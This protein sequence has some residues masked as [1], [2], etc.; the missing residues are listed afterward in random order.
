MNYLNADDFLDGIAGEA[1]DMEIPGL[2]TVKIRSLEYMDLQRINKMARG[3]EM[4]AGFQI[5]IV[6]LVEPQ[7]NTEQIERLKKSKPGVI[8]QIAKR[9]SELSGIRDDIENLVGSGS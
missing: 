8:A 9:V 4:E 6:G 5:A 3:D 7:L 1:V 2:G